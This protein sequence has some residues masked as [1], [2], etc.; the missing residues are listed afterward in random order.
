MSTLK[1]F[2]ALLLFPALAVSADPGLR[3][4]TTLTLNGE[5][6]SQPV[7]TFQEG[8]PVDMYLEGPDR[9]IRIS[10]FSSNAGDKQQL[11]VQLFEADTSGL[12]A[13][14]GEPHVSVALG[15]AFSVEVKSKSGQGY[16]FEGVLSLAQ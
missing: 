10:M 1:L 7:V 8:Q 12:W 5:V 16:R 11:R 2:L 3:A 15:D 14:I 4:N 9:R 6:V 13:L